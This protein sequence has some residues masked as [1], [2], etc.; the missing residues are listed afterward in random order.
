MRISFWDTYT[1]DSFLLLYPM[2]SG[3]FPNSLRHYSR[4]WCNRRPCSRPDP[5]NPRNG[6][7]TFLNNGLSLRPESEN[8]KN[9]ILTLV[10]QEKSNEEEE[11]APSTDIVI[12][13][14]LYLS[15]LIEQTLIS[16][17]TSHI[18]YPKHYPL[19]NFCMNRLLHL[20]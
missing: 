15:Y 5:G 18:S 12:P 7:R 10:H 16:G 20:E 11:E 8:P 3:I 6:L 1:P 14:S 19:Y 13:M 9:S 17:S 4:H 2:N